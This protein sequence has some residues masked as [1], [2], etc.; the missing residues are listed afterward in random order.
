MCLIALWNS[1]NNCRQCIFEGNLPD[2]IYQISFIY[3][4][5][6]KNTVHIYQ[7]CFPQ[8]MMSACV[9][10][11]KEH[12]DNFNVILSRQLSSVDPGSNLHNECM[13]EAHA[14]AS[15]LSEVGVDFK[16]LVEKCRGWRICWRV[17]W[18]GSKWLARLGLDSPLYFEC[19]RTQSPQRYPNKTI[20][21]TD[22]LFLWLITFS[23]VTSVFC[24][25]ASRRRLVACHVFCRS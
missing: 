15:M 18:V 3:F 10:W 8:V 14:H 24:L 9:K 25:Q 22:F 20:P 13:E 6:I 2:Y 4:T 19:V 21:A 23:S 17:G 12:V 1:T 16:D 11:A 5:I 7:S